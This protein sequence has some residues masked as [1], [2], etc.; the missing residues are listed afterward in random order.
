MQSFADFLAKKIL[1]DIQEKHL[2]NRLSLITCTY[3]SGNDLIF[4]AKSFRILLPGR[5]TTFLYELEPVSSISF[6]PLL[7]Q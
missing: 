2:N 5:A 1:M 4:K 6:T 7:A 3:A